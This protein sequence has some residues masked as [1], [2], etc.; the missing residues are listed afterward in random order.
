[1]KKINFIEQ[2]E[3]KECGLAC[4]AMMFNYLGL[5]ISL[6]E[7]RNEYPSPQSGL[8]FYH[9]STICKAY[10]FTSSAYK[11]S[12][13]KIPNLYHKAIDLPAIIQWNKG[14]HFVILEKISK[15]HVNIIDPSFGYLKIE[16]DEF[17]KLFTGNIMYISKDN[18]SKDNIKLKKEKN[19]FILKSLKSNHISI[20]IALMISLIIQVFNIL[21]AI[22][23]GDMVDV[24]SNGGILN[25]YTIY[26]Y[27]V[28]ILTFSILFLIL[29]G[30][31]LI[32]LQNKIDFDI[33]KEYFTHF[34][35]LPISFFENR[36][37]GDLIYRST[38]LTQI[39]EIVSTHCLG[40][41]LDFSLMIVYAF[42][43]LKISIK[44]G[45]LVIMLGCLIILFM[46]FFA[47][48]SYNL[49]KKHLIKQTELQEYVAEVVNTMYDIKS[50]A[51]EKSS[52]SIWENIFLKNL[53]LSKQID[54]LALG[55]NSII[56]SIR[57]VQNII[58][59]F[60]GSYFVINQKIT[61]GTLLSFIVIAESF[62]EP[63]FSLCSSYSSLIQI[64][65]IFQRV[66][67]V[68]Q[69]NVE[70]SPTDNKLLCDTL[71]GK[72]EFK[73]VSFRFNKFEPLILDNISFTIYPGETVWLQGESGA[74]K[75]TIIKLIYGIYKPTEGTILIDSIPI[76]SYDIISLRKCISEVLQE[77]KLFN[78][79]ISEN[80]TLA[81]S[82][83]NV[84]KLIEAIY[85]AK[86]DQVIENLSLKEE[87][88]IYENGAN[89]SG[90]QRQ[91][92]LIAR[93]LY[94]N[95]NI[96]LLDEATNS[97]DKE[98]ESFILEQIISKNITTIIITHDN[99]ILNSYNKK[100]VL[101]DKKVLVINSALEC[102]G[103]NDPI[104]V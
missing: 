41:L 18:I 85:D 19:K 56:T 53:K 79:S 43:M 65:S 42:I 17:E 4:L 98:T 89:F 81:S 72:I 46:M 9:M 91:R 83:Y 70:Y 61:V 99:D 93:A 16:R 63:I 86:L 22:M 94:K 6:S 14:N 33:S 50:Y 49:S 59:F 48:I 54:R 103:E 77:S 13:N 35:K 102:K 37:Q 66:D 47:P 26:M 25:S 78:K 76:E 44:M 92:L 73:N 24:V 34:L 95:P 10:N 51:I 67:D 62:I 84:D 31:I 32:F 12:K 82:V 3:K 52:F 21:P 64:S 1:M 88:L 29:R 60:I 80:I 75:S 8:S 58:I 90:G 74:G 96:L 27:I 45:L 11:I 38:L 104:R 15:K 71:I 100:L 55:I 57:L 39:R 97:L 5:N 28:G 20:A 23:F 69:S 30:N 2:I 36:Q 101:Q 87:T 68:F 7:L 40:I